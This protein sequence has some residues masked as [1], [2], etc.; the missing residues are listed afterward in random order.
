M[1]TPTST[2]KNQGVPSLFL[3]FNLTRVQRARIQFDPWHYADPELSGRVRGTHEPNVSNLRP[4]W[5]VQIR[6]H[7]KCAESA[8]KLW[9]TGMEPGTVERD[10][11][12]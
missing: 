7:W 10:G 8:D 2:H 3:A 4:H 12:L 11:G 6:V 5:Q 1:R 9:L